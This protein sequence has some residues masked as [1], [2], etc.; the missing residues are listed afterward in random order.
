MIYFLAIR[1]IVISLVLQNIHSQFTKFLFSSTISTQAEFTLGIYLIKDIFR[2]FNNQRDFISWFRL[3]TPILTKS[4]YRERDNI[5]R[6]H[7]KQERDNIVTRHPY[8]E[9]RW[10]L[11]GKKSENIKCVHGKDIESHVWR[12]QNE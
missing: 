10:N 7:R 8:R 3:S 9:E 1:R 12:K 6:Q 2:W 11:P 4:E 5:A